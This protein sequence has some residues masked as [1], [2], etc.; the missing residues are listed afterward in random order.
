MKR[1]TFIA[2]VCLALI[3][4]SLSAQ[5]YFTGVPSYSLAART[6][7]EFDYKICRGL[8]ASVSEEIRFVDSEK[9]SLMRSYTGAGLSYKVC[10][11]FETGVSYTFIAAEKKLEEG[12]EP[13]LR[14]RASFDVKGMYGFGKFKLSLR[15]RVQGTFRTDDYNRYQNPGV[16]L[17]LRSRLKLS[18][19]PDRVPLKPYAFVEVK[20]SLNAVNLN[21]WKGV[22]LVDDVMYND[23]YLTGVRAALGTGWRLSKKNSID[24]RLMYD[25]KRN[26]DID[27]TKKGKLKAVCGELSNVFSL[28]VY[29][30]FS[31]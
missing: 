12:R 25:F 16:A 24:F 10:P 8:H 18:Y 22:E 17:C 26:K 21:S 9:K 6:G 30:K 13:W 19:A 20:N 28:A 5:E 3:C 31:L 4:Q 29:Y 7:A 14:H 27:A 23:V 15:E 1:L 11:Y 2:S